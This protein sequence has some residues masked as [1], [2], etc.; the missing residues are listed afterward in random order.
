M[1]EHILSLSH[2]HWIKKT[3]S[4]KQKEEIFNR[5][6]PPQEEMRLII[7]KSASSISC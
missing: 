7:I 2:R 3:H 6:T 1:Q 5:K 4:D